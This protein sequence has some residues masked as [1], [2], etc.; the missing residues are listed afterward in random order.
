MQYAIRTERGSGTPIP[1][2]RRTAAAGQLSKVVPEACGTA[3]TAIKAL[4]VRGGR[5]VAVYRG[6][7]DGQVEVEVGVEVPAPVG[8]HGEVYDSAT[9]AGEVVTT[10]HLGPYGRLGAAHDAI[11]A[12]CSAHGRTP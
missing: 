5:H 3:W 7:A 9:P 2:V 8:R 10:I 1:V 6:G 4:G 11:R 12:W